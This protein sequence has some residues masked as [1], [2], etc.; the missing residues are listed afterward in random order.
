MAVNAGKIESAQ[1]WVD[2]KV[3]QYIGK[4]V[5]ELKETFL[6]EKQ[7]TKADFANLARNMLEV[8]G[9][10]FT[11]PGDVN[12]VL[13]TVRVMGNGKPAENMSFMTVNFQEWCTV[14]SWQD[15]SLYKYFDTT[16][17][18]FFVFQQ[19]TGGKRVPDDEM[20]FKGV[21]LEF[22]SNYD[23]NHGIKQVWDE[24][25]SLILENRL[26]IVP[27]EQKS[28]KIVMKNNLPAGGFNG[29]AHIR[30]GGAN[31]ADVVTL[32]NGQVIAKQR[33]WFNAGF[34]SEFIKDVL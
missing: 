16:A 8:S 24:V 21:K 33:F 29:I 12:T 32:P 30:P 2:A 28:G 3:Q 10:R 7:N 26:E 14:D 11:L 22:V 18:L 27:F 23:L 15:C 6:P 5:Q 4:T 17:I 19:Y 31:G 1:H 34:V 9:N 25:R 20:V 13:K